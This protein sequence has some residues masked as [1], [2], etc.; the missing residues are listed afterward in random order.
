MADR[1]EKLNALTTITCTLTS[2]ATSSTW[3][4]G[5]ESAEIS[6]TA[7]LMLDRW[8]SGQIKVG[9]TPTVNTVI[10]VW[11]IP[12]LNDTTWPDVFAGADAA[13]TVTSRAILLNVAK[14]LCALQVDSTTTGRVYS[15]GRW[16]SAALEGPL[17]QSFSIFVTHNTGV[18]LDATTQVLSQTPEYETVI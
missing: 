14:L 3:V 6:N 17:P 13:R 2:L 16:A 18:N 10:E 7:E 9:T 1:K 12:K 15:F 11:L 4:A 8:L 5:R